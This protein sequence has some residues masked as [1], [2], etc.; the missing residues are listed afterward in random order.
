MALVGSTL[1]RWN[2]PTVSAFQFRRLK[3]KLKLYSRPFAICTIFKT[4]Q[5][6]REMRASMPR[7]GRRPIDFTPLFLALQADCTSNKLVVRLLQVRTVTFSR[8]SSRKWQS[9]WLVGENLAG[10][11]LVL[12]NAWICLITSFSF[13]GNNPSLQIRS[14]RENRGKCNRTC[15]PTDRLFSFV[16]MRQDLNVADSSYLP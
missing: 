14:F 13:V 11:P 15:D 6:K 7:C 2:I 9:L 12:K 1:E 8:D 16:P 4:P 10:S 5:S 3:I